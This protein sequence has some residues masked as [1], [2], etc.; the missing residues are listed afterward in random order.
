M[1]YLLQTKIPDQKPLKIGL[2]RFKGLG[3]HQAQ[4][5]CDSLGIDPN[6]PIEKLQNDQI[7]K[8]IK[9]LSARPIGLQLDRQKKENILRLIQI[10]SYRGIRHVQGLPVRGQRT[11]DNAQ[12][13]KRL[14][15]FAWTSKST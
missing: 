6:T 2:L 8:L 9:T 13:S 12:T 4:K 14:N 1:I 10:S 3:A 5:L 15:S 7:Q 11:R